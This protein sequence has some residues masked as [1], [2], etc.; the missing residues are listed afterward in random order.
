MLTENR[1]VKQERAGRR[2]WFE[3]EEIELIVWYHPAG[4]VDGFQ[5]CYGR[6]DNSRALTWRTGAGFAHSRID[7]GDTTPLKNETPVLA[8]DGTVP[9]AEVT[10]LF[11]DRSATLEAPL[12]DLVLKKLADQG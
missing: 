7:A 11:R 4:E 2:R 6:P 5:I 1:N 9:W 8:P 3:D 10:A 12:R